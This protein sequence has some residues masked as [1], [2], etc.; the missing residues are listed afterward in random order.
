MRIV[1]LL[2]VL[3]LASVV[4]APLLLT[5]TARAQGARL[6]LTIGV[7]PGGRLQFSPATILIPF[8]N[9]TLNVTFVNNYTAPGADH[10]FTISNANQDHVIDTGFI[11]PGGNASVEFRVVTMTNI[12]YNGTFFRPEAIG[13]AIRFFCI[14]HDPQGMQGRIVL[15]SETAPELE[16]GI[17]LRAYWIGIIGIA[18]MLGWVGI[19]YFILKTSSRHFADHREHVRRGL[20]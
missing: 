13:T 5:T 7:D 4:L 8:V 3:S 20:P 19:V 16:K 11:P 15:A 9:V 1:A 12:S 2:V 6:E 18:A 10:T 17:L 14:P